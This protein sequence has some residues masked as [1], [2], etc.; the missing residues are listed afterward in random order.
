MVTVGRPSVGVSVLSAPSRGPYLADDWGD[1]T[2]VA[3][4]RARHPAAR[5]RR[6]RGG[7]CP[8]FGGDTREETDP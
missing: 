8:R 7:S 1:D 4:W 6:A 5:D 2:L 3:C